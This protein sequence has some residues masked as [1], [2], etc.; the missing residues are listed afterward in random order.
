MKNCA[1]LNVTFSDREKLDSKKQLKRT[2]EKDLV[3]PKS[4]HSLG[5]KEDCCF[6]QNMKRS[7]PTQECAQSWRKE[8]CGVKQDI[9]K[10]L[11]YPRSMPSLEGKEN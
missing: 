2:V 10:D 4:M 6:E 11:V 8:D 5:E 7:G 1:Q 9:K 3:H